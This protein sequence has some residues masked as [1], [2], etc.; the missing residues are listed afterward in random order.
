MFHAKKDFIKIRFPKKKCKRCSDNVY[1]DGLQST[2]ISN[3]KKCEK[4]YYLQSEDSCIICPDNHYCPGAYINDPK[5]AIYENQKIP[6]G[7]KSLTIPPNNL[8]VSHLNCLCKKGFEFIKTDDNEFDCLE[9]PKNYYK[10]HLGNKEKEPCPENSVTLYTQTK[11][12]VKCLCMPGYY[13]DLKEFKC[14]K[15]PK[16]HYCPGG[17]LKNCFNNQN[18]HSCKPQK[19]EMS[20]KKFN[21]TN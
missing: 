21:Y 8:N 13:W 15:C 16:G 5:Y 18:L 7:D 10:S 4:G 1:T 11:S 19:K 14:I 12:K 6:C 9:V 20:F 17:Y 3:C 2:S